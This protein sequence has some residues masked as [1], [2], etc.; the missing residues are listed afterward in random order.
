M[1]TESIIAYLFQ[2]YY[3]YLISKLTKKGK[4]WWKTS[5]FTSAF[6][7]PTVLVLQMG[8]TFVF[9]LFLIFLLFFICRHDLYMYICFRKCMCFLYFRKLQIFCRVNTYLF[10]LCARFM[11]IHKNNNT[12]LVLENF[13]K[14]LL[15]FLYPFLSNQ[16]N[17]IWRFKLIEK[18]KFEKH[19][20]T[21]FLSTL[22]SYL[23]KIKIKNQKK[24]AH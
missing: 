19:F 13:T 18:K 10:E 22:F 9:V 7:V 8:S 24:R 1:L 12:K 17:T 23:N 16:I 4:R 2:Y 20:K 3:L 6:A 11:L 5:R 15:G 14:S 21:S